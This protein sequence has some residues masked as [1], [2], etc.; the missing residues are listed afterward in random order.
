MSKTF[1][2]VT[3]GN[4]HVLYA[5]ASAG[6]V[7]VAI[8][9]KRHS[10]I[11]ISRDDAPALALA[12]LE[13]AGFTSEDLQGDD[14]DRHFSLAVHHLLRGIEE[15]ERETAAAREQAELE[16]EARDFYDAYHSTADWPYQDWV[17]LEER[18]KAQFYAV[19]RRA[20]ELGGRAEK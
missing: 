5:H 2:S 18:Y 4:D 10:G 1:K 12:I 7:R 9:G 6:Q 16:A 11:I 13:A 8:E 19:A 20:R 17:M 3:P 14:S 15:R